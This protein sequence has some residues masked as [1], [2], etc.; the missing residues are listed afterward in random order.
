MRY[1]RIS[2]NLGVYRDDDCTIFMVTDRES[3]YERVVCCALSKE[4]I[5]KLRKELGR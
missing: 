2:D 4:E 1:T 3:K 5:E